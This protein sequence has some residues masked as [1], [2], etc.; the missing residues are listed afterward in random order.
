V[1]KNLKE[2]P[3]LK[4]SVGQKERPKDRINGRMMGS[5]KSVFFVGE[6]LD[7]LPSPWINTP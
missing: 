2:E 3:T 6:L 7:K 1:D 4:P 5:I